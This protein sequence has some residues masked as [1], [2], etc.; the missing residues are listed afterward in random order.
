[1]NDVPVFEGFLENFTPQDINVNT[2]STPNVFGYLE[3]E[4]INLTQYV[5]SGTNDRFLEYGP[6]HYL[7]TG[8]PG[9]GRNVGIAGHR[10]TYGA[11]FRDLDYV[12]LG[13]AIQ[14]TIDSSKF[15]YIV[16][17]IDIV[18]AIGGEYVLYDRGDD[19][20]TLTTCHPKYSAG[21]RLIVSAILVKIESVN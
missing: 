19:R 10:T 8:T 21:K 13:D 3:I 12:N 6:G 1:M 17:Q 20:L 18:D 15:Y 4:A 16:D 2:L 11:P 5:V 14:L 9:K 7:S